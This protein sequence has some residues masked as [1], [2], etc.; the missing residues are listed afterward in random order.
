MKKIMLIFIA[1]ATF[2]L[3]GCKK[4]KVVINSAADLEGKKIGVQTGTTGETWV[5]ENLKKAKL[6]SFK[7]GIDAALDLKNGSIDAVVL[8]ELPAKEI[9]AR[10]SDLAI[11]RDSIFTENKEEYAIAVKKGNWQLLNIINSTVAEIKSN[12]DYEKL[13]AAFMPADGNVVIPENEATE[14]TQSLKLGTNAAFP[15]FEY[16]DG[17]NIVGFDI[18]MGQKIAKNAGKTLDIVDMAFDSLIPALQSGTIDFIAAGMSVTE[19]RKKN[20]DFSAPYFQSE[21]VIIVKK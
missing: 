12:G 8:D 20:V 3:F 10:N 15:P 6:S 5:I 4:E 18:S 1:F 13:V 21:Q 2:C 14:G 19:E 16:V 7:T 11:I 9:V 17:K